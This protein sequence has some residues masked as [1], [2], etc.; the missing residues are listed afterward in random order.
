LATFLVS[1]LLLTGLFTIANVYAIPNSDVPAPDG[2]PHSCEVVGHEQFIDGTVTWADPNTANWQN[3]VLQ[4][5]DES[6][7]QHRSS[8]SFGA[9]GD[10]REPYTASKV[11]D[12]RNYR[13]DLNGDFDLGHGFINEFP[14]IGGGAAC[15]PKYYFSPTQT[16]GVTL[17]N[18]N[19]NAQDMITVAFDMWSAVE[20]DRPYLV[21]GIEFEQTA[22]PAQA[23]VTIYWQPHNALGEWDPNTRQLIFASNRTW[24]FPLDPAGTPNDAYHFFTTAIH[25][26]GHV[27][28][29]GDQN[30]DHDVMYFQQRR[31]PNGP[32]FDHIDDDSLE[33]IRDLYSISTPDFGDAPDPPYPT[34]KASNGA[35]NL[36]IGREWL[37]ANPTGQT[38]TTW[39]WDARVVDVPDDG[40]VFRL[41]PVGVGG[42]GFVDVTVSVTNW[43][44]SRYNN[45]GHYELYLAI[46]I[47]WDENGAW[48]HPVEMVVFDRLGPSTWKQNTWSHTY[49]FS[50]PLL[51]STTWARARLVY[52]NTAMN[53]FPWGILPISDSPDNGGEVEDYKIKIAPPII[54]EYPCLMDLAHPVSTTLDELYPECGKSYYVVDWHD[55]YGNY[56]LDPCDFIGLY[57]PD[58]CPTQR[59]TWPYWWHVDDIT[60][61]LNVSKKPE[62]TTFMC[63]E[64][65]GGWGG[66]YNVI[67]QP[68]NTQWHEVYPSYGGGYDLPPGGWKDNCDSRLSPCDQI[69]LR[70][71]P[72]GEIAEYHVIRV[73]T[74]ILVSPRYTTITMDKTKSAIGQGYPQTIPVFIENYYPNTTTFN[75]S[76]YYGSSSQFIGSKTMTSD[77]LRSHYVTIPWTETA[78]WLKG[79]YSYNITVDTYADSKLVHSATF[80]IA[81][82]ITI[83]GDIG[84]DGKVDGSDL[85]V[86]AKAFGSYPHHPRWDPN[87]DVN[88]DIVVDGS[89]LII[90]ARH[91]GDADP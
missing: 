52:A 34:K 54:I 49:N 18:W 87:A 42:I 26:T 74:N 19:P 10:R 68:E 64:Y 69:I 1:L 27:A 15:I 65:A 84:G 32:C 43:Q 48:E 50:V 31:G 53:L 91:F 14:D 40:C 20:S 21:T 13:V 76:A 70:Y 3:G 37:G 59:E 56:L 71:G 4:N 44:S 51:W 63:I 29:L 35:R 9:F 36:F 11:W 28:G 6:C 17:C 16:D 83:V 46:W 67:T 85:I 58:L 90:M 38:T 45:L 80:P 23:D 7:H 12:N 79:T 55:T 89:D 61:T 77:P 8:R 78:N 62:E 73:K 25:E 82:N 57:D 72:T 81:F 60:V 33:G 75:V 2:H 5:P 22:N 47:D 41:P 66:Y 39:E 24:Y 30:D 86:A 88:E